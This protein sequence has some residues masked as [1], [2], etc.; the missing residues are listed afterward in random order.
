[1]GYTIRNDELRDKI[2]GLTMGLEL[3]FAFT[4]EM[5]YDRDYIEVTLSM[6]LKSRLQSFHWKTTRGKSPIRQSDN[7]TLIRH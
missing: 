7:D 1:M 5:H 3:F 6:V 2:K 4:N